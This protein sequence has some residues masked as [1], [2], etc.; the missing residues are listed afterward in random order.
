[1]TRPNPLHLLALMSLFMGVSMQSERV[2]AQSPTMPP[3]PLLRAHGDTSV[4]AV[5]GAKTHAWSVGVTD[6]QKNQARTLY[7]A[8]KRY[9]E[10]ALYAA[11]AAKYGAALQHWD[12]PRI[13]YHLA[14]AQISMDRPVQAYGSIV[15]ALRYGADGLRPDEYERGLKR[16]R[17][18]REQIAA[19]EIVCLEPEAAV[20]L[21]GRPLFTGPGRL[22]TLVLPGAYQI[23]ASKIRHISASQIVA[24]AAG[25]STKVELNLLPEDQATI[26]VRRMEPWLPWTVLGVGIGLGAVATGMHW[27]SNIPRLDGREE[28]AARLRNDAYFTYTA[29]GLFLTSGALLVYL[30]RPRVVENK[31]LHNLVRVSLQLG[32]AAEPGVSFQIPF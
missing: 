20:T 31:A 4:P 10:S 3:A 26:Q 24:L 16:R 12:H 1:M 23:I 7:E 29:A 8:G 21:N 19:V 28:H 9:Y 30:N 17:Q 25:S 11:A 6:E 15:Q 5:N 27:H 18:L 14:L 22:T 2:L 13:H 32:S